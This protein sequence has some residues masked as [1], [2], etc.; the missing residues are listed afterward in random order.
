MTAN[1][2]YTD[3]DL[4]ALV[5]K[6]PTSTIYGNRD[7]YYKIVEKIKT[8][9]D[10][11]KG[12]AKKELGSNFVNIEIKSSYDGWKAQIYPKSYVKVYVSYSDAK[13]KQL[14]GFT[15]KWFIETVK[16]QIKDK[17]I[18]DQRVM[19]AAD[20]RKNKENFERRLNTACRGERWSDPITR[21][22]LDNIRFT[23]ELDQDVAIEVAKAKYVELKAIT[24]TL[25]SIK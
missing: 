23:S 20:F 10:T 22:I 18:K 1:N 12:E 13:R 15:K 8:I 4:Q 9:L 6:L 16:E 7:E 25:K 17:E 5:A 24:E 14:K 3:K 19:A 2:T 11:W 21:I